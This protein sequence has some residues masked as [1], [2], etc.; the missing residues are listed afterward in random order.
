MT[1]SRMKGW[2]AANSHVF[3]VCLDTLR[4]PDVVK[5]H[6]LLMGNKLAEDF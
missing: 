4:Y 3:G 2:M 5:S 1:P 6:V